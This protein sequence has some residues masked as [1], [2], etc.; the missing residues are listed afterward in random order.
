MIFIS[1][2]RLI[3]LFEEI[4]DNIQQAINKI[5]SISVGGIEKLTVEKTTK[6]INAIKIAALI[7]KQDY[8]GKGVGREVM[9]KI[10]EIA[11]KYQVSLYLEAVP[12]GTKDERGYTITPTYSANE[13]IGFYKKFGFELIKG[14]KRPEMIR[15]PK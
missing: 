1:M 6:P 14:G 10:T 15:K 7:I 4:Q 9:N 5:N 8:Q 13:L 2:I 11:D 12:L 3:D